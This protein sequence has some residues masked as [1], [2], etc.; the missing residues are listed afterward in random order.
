MVKLDIGR[1]YIGYYHHFGGKD[2]NYYY[3]YVA[4]GQKV[5]CLDD[6]T[7]L[8]NC[9]TKEEYYRIIKLKILW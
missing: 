8:E 9:K 3:C 7:I 2:V 5:F 1:S 4:N 6:G